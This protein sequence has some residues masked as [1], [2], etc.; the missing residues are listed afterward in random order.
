MTLIT[1]V[2][3]YIN[4]NE[5]G[6]VEPVQLMTYEEIVAMATNEWSR[7]RRNT[8]AV[9]NEHPQE[10]YEMLNEQWKIYQASWMLME[11]CRDWIVWIWRTD[12]EWISCCTANNY[13]RKAAY[14]D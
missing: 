13:E 12:Y 3:W 9:L 2:K 4:G 1:N 10:Y 8:V 7:P 6:I 14:M 11:W 5:W